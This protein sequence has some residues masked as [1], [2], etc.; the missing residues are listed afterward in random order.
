MKSGTEF[1]V[2]RGEGMGA[3]IYTSYSNYNLEVCGRK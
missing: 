1:E 2:K 3:F